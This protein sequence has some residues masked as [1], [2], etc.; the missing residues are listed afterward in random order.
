MYVSALGANKFCIS[1]KLLI[2]LGYD[3]EEFAVETTKYR[4]LVREY[5]CLN[6]EFS[7]R[8]GTT[9]ES[10]IPSHATN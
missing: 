6:P 4:K 1:R 9:S 8:C 7:L 5:F 10:S 2:Q 3:P